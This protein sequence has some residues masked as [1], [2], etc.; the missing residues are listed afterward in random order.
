MRE[1]VKCLELLF[2]SLCHAVPAAP[3]NYLPILLFGCLKYC[4]IIYY[5]ELPGLKCTPV[6]PFLAFVNNEAKVAI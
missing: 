6:F 5:A 3:E 2:I 4:T 1:R